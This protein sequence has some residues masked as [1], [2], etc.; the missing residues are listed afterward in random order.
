[1]HTAHQMNKIV[2]IPGSMA[3]PNGL[4]FT[5]GQITWTT[6]SDDFIAMTTEEARIQSASTTT[7]PALAT[8]PTTADTAPTTVDTAPTTMDMAPTT[9][10]MALTTMDPAPTAVHL[11]PTMPASSSATPITCRPLPRYKGKQIDNTDLLDSIDRVGTKL[12]ETLALVSTIQSQPN[13]QVTAPHN[14]STRPARTSRPA[15]LGTDLV[16]ISTP[17]G[18][19]ARRRPAFVMSLRLSEYEASTENHQVQPYGP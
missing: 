12:A 19:S 14:R 18:R 9:T 4:T 11:A 1:M 15:R 17:E 3:A 10:D 13:E 2:I 6:G 8:A 16:V 5:I 7:S